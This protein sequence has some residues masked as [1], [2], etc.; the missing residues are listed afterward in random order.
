[1]A[2]LSGFVTTVTMKN[3]PFYIR[4]ITR[5]LLNDQLYLIRWLTQGVGSRGF[6]RHKK[7]LPEMKMLRIGVW[8]YIIILAPPRVLCLTMVQRKGNIVKFLILS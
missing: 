7:W 4:F 8:F 1:M 2:L 6:I 3:I 5:Q